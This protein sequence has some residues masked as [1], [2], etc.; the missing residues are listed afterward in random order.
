MTALDNY[1]AAIEKMYEQTELSNEMPGIYSD[2]FKDAVIAS[3]L[4]EKEYCK[5]SRSFGYI[6]FSCLVDLFRERGEIFDMVA[7]YI[8]SEEDHE[9]A[10]KI[11]NSLVKSASLY[12]REDIEIDVE[13]LYRR[14]NCEIST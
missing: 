14:K 12:Y 11:A 8:K 9:M 10:I 3:L 4:K 13:N 1:S 5:K 2:S 7:T 6:Q